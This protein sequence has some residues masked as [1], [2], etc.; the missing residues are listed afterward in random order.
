MDATFI[1]DL[2]RRATDDED[3]ACLLS[4]LYLAAVIG[5]NAKRL[6]NAPTRSRVSVK[7]QERV[8][9]AE[10]KTANRALLV[11]IEFLNVT[12]WFIDQSPVTGSSSFALASFNQSGAIGSAFAFVLRPAEKLFAQNIGGPGSFVTSQET[13]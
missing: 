11:Y 9:V 7:P 13:Y 12:G 3:E 10:N 4:R 2:A 5:R 1:T 6:P 8:Q